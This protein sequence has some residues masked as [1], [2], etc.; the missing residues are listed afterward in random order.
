MLRVWFEGV[1]CDDLRA[2]GDNRSSLREPTGIEI[3][4]LPK[5]PFLH[6][7]LCMLTN[8]YAHIINSAIVCRTSLKN[9]FPHLLY[10]AQKFCDKDW[11]RTTCRRLKTS[12]ELSAL[13][14]LPRCG[15]VV[16]ELRDTT[17]FSI[18]ASRTI[19]FQG[20]CQ[21]LGSQPYQLTHNCWL[22]QW[23]IWHV[24]LGHCLSS[25]QCTHSWPG[26]PGLTSLASIYKK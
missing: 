3:L 12:S 11:V 15:R 8:F 14:N 25:E 16:S 13:Q 19:L 17:K 18:H 24:G 9:K 7:N 2:I 6:K 1:E 10:F 4:G 23:Q 5:F 20:P 26:V 22:R 21:V